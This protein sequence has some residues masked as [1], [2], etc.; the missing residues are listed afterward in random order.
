MPWI[1]HYA[2]ATNKMNHRLNQE[3]DNRSI[4]VYN[5]VVYICDSEISFAMRIDF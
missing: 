5:F 2:H 3:M 4:Y 1:L